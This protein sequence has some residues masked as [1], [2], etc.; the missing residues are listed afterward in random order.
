MTSDQVES[1]GGSLIQHGPLNDRAY[2]MKLGGDIAPEVAAY[3]NALAI[4]KGYSK[5]FA[6]VPG[7]AR[8]AFTKMDFIEEARIPGLFKRKE[9][10]CFL[11]KFLSAERESEKHA[12]TVAEVLQSALQKNGEVAEVKLIDNCTCRTM[13]KCDVEEM[14]R[15]YSQVFASYPF[16]I[17]DPDY[18]ASTMDDSLIYFGIWDGGRL[19]ALS[20]AEVDFDGS[21]AEMTDFAT[22]PEYRGQGLATYLLREMESGIRQIGIQTAYTIARAYSFGMNITFAKQGYIHGGTLVNNT[23]ISGALESMNIWHKH[24]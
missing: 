17:H 22:L 10:G 21:N 1:F 23:Q 19:I 13:R 18:L 16:P 4:T 6:K 8:P 2:V 5:I 20:S 24:L 14:A 12:H 11:S 3:V 7:A 15:L 9:D